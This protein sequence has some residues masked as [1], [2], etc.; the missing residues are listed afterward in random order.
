MLRK[1]GFTLVELLV[2]MAVVG[3]LMA[4]LLPAVQS[5]REAARRTKCA[6][7]LHQLGLAITMYCDARQG[8]FP[9][10]VHTVEAEKAWI[11]T[12][13]PYLESV[14]KVRLCPV[15]PHAQER[16]E[17]KL[18]SYALNGYLTVEV[19]G[20]KRN[21]NRLRSTTRTVLAWELAD[22]KGVSEHNDHV[23]SYNW[24]RRTNV[25]RDLVWRSVAGDIQTDRHANGTH[26][27][28]VDSRVEWIA[29]EEIRQWCA[30]ATNFAKPE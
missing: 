13:A 27:L 3:A 12:L 9:D 8:W 14:D 20:A 15:D 21:R 17:R 30:S 25:E 16:F 28:Y 7:N 1:R 18:T 4:L 11:N 10:T 23:H 19:P 2:V 6:S 5:A 29:A 22:L 24:F 26:F